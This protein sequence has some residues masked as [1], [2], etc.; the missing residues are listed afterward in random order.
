MVAVVDKSR[1]A[2]RMA[3]YETIAIL[4]SAFTERLGIQGVLTRVRARYCPPPS[5]DESVSA[6]V[7]TTNATNRPQLPFALRV[8]GELCPAIDSSVQQI[9]V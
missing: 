2:T 9:D 5:L 6:A 8:S 4:P 3:D 7:A 1:Y